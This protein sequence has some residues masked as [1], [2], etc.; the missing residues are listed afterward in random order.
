[1]TQ[2]QKVQF[3]GKNKDPTLSLEQGREDFKQKMKNFQPQKK[4]QKNDQF[5]VQDDGGSK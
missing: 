1:M 5:A 2:Q 4:Q 3:V